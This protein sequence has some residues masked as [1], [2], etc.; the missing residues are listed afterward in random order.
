MV[1]LTYCTPQVLSLHGLHLIELIAAYEH[2][3]RPLHK[4][5]GQQGLPILQ[6]PQHVIDL[7]DAVSQFQR[8]ALPVGELL[9]ALVI[10]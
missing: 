5:A 10:L 9:Q 8:A 2:L 3:M 1:S 7:D 4:G 6:V